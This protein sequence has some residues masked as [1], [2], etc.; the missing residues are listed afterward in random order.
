EIQRVA[1]RNARIITLEGDRGIEEGDIAVI[2]YEGFIGGEPFKGGKQDDCQL[3]IGK[4]RFIKGFEEQLIGAK[5]GE[6]KEIT[7]T[8]PED[9]HEKSLAGKETVFKVAVKRI[10]VKELPAIDDEFAKDVS[11]FDTLE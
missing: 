3:E 5:A 10:S 2:D 8:F 4:G 1:E 6:E 7:V 11:E 9:Y